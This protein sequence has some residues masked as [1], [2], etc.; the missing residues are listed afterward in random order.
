M[1]VIEVENLSKVYRLGYTGTGNLKD[2]V[3]GWWARIRGKPNPNALVG[4]INDRTDSKSDGYV[5]ALE[6]INFKVDQGEVLGIIGKNGAGKSTLLKILTKITGPTTGSIKM[7]GRV[8]S[9]LEVGT[10]FNP[11]LSGRENIYLNGAILGM[12]K[13]EIDA[14]FLDIVEFAG[15]AKYIDT[16]VKRYSSGMGVRLGFAVA[17]FLEPEVLIIDEVLAVG[18]AQFQAQAIGKMQE[19]S[20]GGGRTVLFVSHSM[21]SIKKLCSRCILL[22]NGMLTEN[23][24]TGMVVDKYL[25]LSSNTTEFSL[26]KRLS[27]FNFSKVRITDI[28]TYNSTE[29]SSIIK[30][31]QDLTIKISYETLEP[32]GSPAFGITI[33]D[34]D[35]HVLFRISNM[36]ISGHIIKDLGKK[37]V[38]SLTIKNLPL[39]MGHYLIDV[40][41]AHERIEW[42]FTLEDIV[43]F[44]VMD[45]NPYPSLFELDNRRG[46]MWVNHSWDIKTQK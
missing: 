17:A 24:D 28:V 38:A 10:G 43:R 33:K 35:R 25:A 20:K 36:P 31:N 39:T 37:G 32:V 6:D 30:A 26:E 4:S 9:L 3:S 18:D 27:D 45:C 19:I 22:E 2:D 29:N 34:K 46:I 41:F 13:K 12:R 7:K 23:G 5:N 21:G 42:F 14:K 40:G 15:V 8:G 44:E 16:P 1:K 11:E